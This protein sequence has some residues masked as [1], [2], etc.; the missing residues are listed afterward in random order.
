MLKRIQISHVYQLRLRQLITAY[1]EHQKYLNLCKFY[2]R[3]W[4]ETYVEQKQLE[5]IRT[6]EMNE[7]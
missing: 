5:E 4:C 1:F 3:V 7:S 6:D 2:L